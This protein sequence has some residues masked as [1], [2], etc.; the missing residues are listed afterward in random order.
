MKTT[1]SKILAL[2][3]LLGPPAMAERT[4]EIRLLHVAGDAPNEK[5]LQRL[6][7]D[8]GAQA[9]EKIEASVAA[10]GKVEIKKVTPY[11]YPSEY[12]VAGEPSAFETRDLGVSGTGTLADKEA[13]TVH[14]KFDLS[15]TLL[16]A[17]R[18]YEVKGTQVFMPVFTQVTSPD[19]ELSMRP[20]EWSF[21]K[22]QIGEENYFWAI[23][24][25]NK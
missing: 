4:I 17:P 16:S 23:R 7:D 15:G 3:L 9:A 1:H 6:V 24:L 14:L 21:V 11:R 12:T 2:S 22:R 19:E 5:M 10:G 25:K 13:G 8:A 18:V 20:G